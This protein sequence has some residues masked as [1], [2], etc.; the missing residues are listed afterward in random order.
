MPDTRPFVPPP[1]PYER[2]DRFKPLAEH[3]EGGLV[4]LSIGTPCDPPPA[5]VIE[6]LS[7]SNAERGYPPS[8]GTPRLRRA[9]ADWIARRFSVDV[10]IDHVAA[11]VGTKEFEDA[12][13]DL[14]MPVEFGLDTMNEFIDWTKKIPFQ[15]ERGE[16]PGEVA[17]DSPV[18]QPDVEPQDRGEAARRIRRRR[19]VS[20]GATGLAR[21]ANR[22]VQAAPLPRHLA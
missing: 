4:D 2:I 6:A 11:C 3:F 8:V 17:I 20:P 16:G 18:R 13:R 19:V 10:D 7:N 15:V 5:S 22:R 21:D 12:V 1:Y 9:A 14:A